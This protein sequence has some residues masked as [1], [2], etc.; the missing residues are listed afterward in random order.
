M[1]AVAALLLLVAWQRRPPFE[2]LRRHLAHL[3]IDVGPATTMEEALRRARADDAAGLEP[4]VALYEAERFSARPPRGVRGAIR[5]G[6]T[7]R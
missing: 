4:L 6:L 1:T 3:G 7:R 2:L 5:K